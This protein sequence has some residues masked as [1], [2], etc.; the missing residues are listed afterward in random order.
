MSKGNKCL[1]IIDL[2]RQA[3]ILNIPYSRRTTRRALCDLVNT[4][5]AR[6]REISS[7]VV[8][9][10]KFSAILEDGILSERRIN[11][12]VDRI[13]NGSFTI[14]RSPPFDGLFAQAETV[15]DP[16]RDLK[17]IATDFVVNDFFSTE[18]TLYGFLKLVYG[19]FERAIE[20][21]AKKT[22]L[23]ASGKLLFMYKGG[24]VMRMVSNEFILELP[25]NATR[26]IDSFY[27]PFFKRSDADF[28]IYIHPEIQ[29]YDRVYKDMTYLAYLLQWQ[30]REAF[31]SSP[32]DFFDFFK[33]NDEYRDAI[34]EKYVEALNKQENTT[35]FVEFSLPQAEA[36]MT[37][38]VVANEKVDSARFFIDNDFGAKDRKVAGKNL[39]INRSFLPVTFNDALDFATGE[40]N[41]RRAKFTLVRT[42]VLFDIAERIDSTIKRSSTG[43]EL[44]DVSIPHR[45]DSNVAHFFESLSQNVTKFTL[46]FG[47]NEF[48]FNSLSLKY[49]VDD[50]QTILFEFNA[51]PWQDKKYEKR[52]HRLFYLYFVQIFVYV[53]ES[54]NRLRVL[55]L[56]RDTVLK[57]LLQDP[58]TNLTG[59]LE[60]KIGRSPLFVNQ[61]VR[62]MQRLTKSL[63]LD[64]VEQ[65]KIM[66]QLLI[67]DVNMMV[68]VIEQV[69]QYCT[70]GGMVNPEDIYAIDI[71]A[72]K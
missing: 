64:Q 33:F 59:Y 69:Q 43:G 37:G 8:T 21:Y 3:K 53:R 61:F 35:R 15:D 7:N 10:Q 47:E 38:G 70:T 23:D 68:N 36:T 14:D 50:L 45:L 12:A 19:S 24:N 26:Q 11:D 54:A 52:I 30:I 57:P 41:S 46:T 2:K 72:L 5:I 4:E 62:F 56:V 48:S 65:F 39:T 28:S 32:V 55:E 9:T 66:V 51:L 31:L 1:N 16:N 29:N 17:S 34:E 71:D 63:P 60:S 42:K 67:D 27:K 49:L 40:N 58:K 18:E 20:Y 44:I 25:A 13:I 6:R 22:G